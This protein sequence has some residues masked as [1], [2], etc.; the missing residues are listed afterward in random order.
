MTLLLVVVMLS[1]LLL[2]SELIPVSDLLSGM[3]EDNNVRFVLLQLRLPRTLTAVLAGAAL[4]ISGLL[5]QSYFRN[6]LA[7]PYILG[8]SSGSGL[9]VAFLMMVGSLL[10]W[11]F[12][13]LQNGVM[14][15]SV[16][17]A[18]LVLMLVMVLSSRIGNG[19]MLLIT[20]LMIGSF[21]SALVSIFQFF[22]PSQTIKKYLLWTMGSLS[23]V[24]LDGLLWFG[25]IIVLMI[26][27][28]FYF[29]KALNAMLLGEQQAQNLGIAP[30][31]VKWVVLISSGILA[32][33]VTAY[34]GPIAFVGLSAPHIA[35][36]WL[37][38]SDHRKLIPFTAFV[39]GLLLLICDMIAQ[40]PGFSVV[41][42]INAITSLVGAPLVVAV[43]LRNRKFWLSHG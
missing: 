38:T 19:A 18:A 39:G 36:L 40:V 2:G 27:V 43:V 25:L 16:A 7:G 6:P 24:E 11:E 26:L 34:C 15:F 4:G 42:P 37:K 22:A 31:Q 23:S 10:G 5:M 33:T 21:A 14:I 13:S 28:S 20:G 9:G 8:I 35:R 30:A 29:S 32:G 17:G 1:S 12:G 41:L 3:Q